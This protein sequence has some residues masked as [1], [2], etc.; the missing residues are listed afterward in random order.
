MDRD[1]VKVLRGLGFDVTCRRR[2]PHIP[3]HLDSIGP[4]ERIV[5][6]V[7]PVPV[8]TD[9][10]AGLVELRPI[11][12]LFTGSRQPPCFGDTPHDEYALFF[13]AIEFTAADYCSVRGVP[14]T[15]REFE[16]LYRHL[17]RRPDGR[18]DNPL[19]SYMQAAVRLYMSLKDVSEAEFDAVVRRLEKSARTFAIGAT[20]RNYYSFALQTFLRDEPMALGM[21]G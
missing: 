8:L 19:F 10:G 9:D 11:S 15:D 4:N 14:D 5:P 3:V 2:V 12:Q 17:R 16:R 13:A 6:I 21:S 1:A 20:S 18:D 7:G